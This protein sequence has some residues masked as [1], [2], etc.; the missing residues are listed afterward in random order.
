MYTDYYCMDDFEG[1]HE[2]T[3]RPFEL[4]VCVGVALLEKKADR[5]A[6]GR[7]LR[8]EVPE[9]QGQTLQQKEVDEAVERLVQLGVLAS[10]SPKGEEVAERAYGL[11]QWGLHLVQK[12]EGEVKGRLAKGWGKKRTLH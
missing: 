1:K 4:L 3:L 12:S 10:F 2:P 5:L 6:L 9:F 7:W 11:S 8:E